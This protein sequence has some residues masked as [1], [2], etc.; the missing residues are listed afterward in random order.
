MTAGKLKI[1][2]AQSEISADIGAN[3][4]LIRS[5][6]KQAAQAGAR[7]VHF[8]E[9]ALSG[10]VKAQI[11]DW[12]D[13]DWAGLRA[14]LEETAALAGRLG[15]WMVLG[16]NHPLTPPNRPHNS[17]YV[18]S[19]QGRLAARYDKRRCSHSE[20]TDWYTPGS[21]ATVFAVDDFRFGCALCI[22]IRFA[23]LFAAY[24]RA[25]VDCML[26]SAYASDPMMGVTAQ[27][28]AAMNLYWLSLSTPAQ[29]SR[30]GEDGLPSGLIAPTGHYAAGGMPGRSM[31]VVHEMDKNAPDL[32]LW[33]NRARPWRRAA[34]EGGIYEP[35]YVSDARSSNRRA[36]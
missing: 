34:R 27:A 5:L 11:K 10:Y 13:V 2:T 4:R 9:G 33:L 24:E 21:E 22:E 31:L 7:L 8:P 20:I 1:A 12:K 17:L 25:D 15:I 3:G 30:G 35:R 32:D 26:F 23:D 28:H 14:E 29:C 19:D 18:I 16:A 6:A 36:F